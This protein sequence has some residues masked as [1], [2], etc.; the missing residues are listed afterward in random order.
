MPGIGSAPRARVV[1]ENTELIVTGVVRA[2]IAFTHLRCGDQAELDELLDARRDSPLAARCEIIRAPNGPGGGYVQHLKRVLPAFVE[3]SRFDHVLVC[4]DDVRLGHHF[5]LPKLR[6]VMARNNLSVASPSVKTPS[7]MFMKP[8]NK[9]RMPSTAVG[10]VTHIL[11]AFALVYTRAAWRCQYELIDVGLNSLGWGYDAWLQNYCSSWRQTTD[12]IPFRMGIDDTMF[13]SHGV[14]AKYYAD[15]EARRKASARI[16]TYST[17]KA[18]EAMYAMERDAATR[19][20]GL[21][22]TNPQAENTLH[23]GWLY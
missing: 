10:R 1:L 5:D 17:P 2:C 21:V 4:L 15:E 23:R 16:T 22:P 18:E 9:S 20:L 19:G 14:P 12:L 7:H 11:E 13:V 8:H 6:N 3:A